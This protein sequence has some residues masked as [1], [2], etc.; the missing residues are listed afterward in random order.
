VPVKVTIQ[1]QA[2]RDIS[3]LMAASGYGSKNFVRRFGA[4]AAGAK[5]ADFSCAKRVAIQRWSSAEL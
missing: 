5:Y 2:T 1:S 3:L 4:I